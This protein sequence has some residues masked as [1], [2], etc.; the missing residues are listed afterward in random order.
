LGPAKQGVGAIVEGFE[1]SQ[2]RVRANEELVELRG[3][4]LLESDFG[5]FPDSLLDIFYTFVK[6]SPHFL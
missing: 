5:F 1:L 2:S 4:M 3:R 6:P